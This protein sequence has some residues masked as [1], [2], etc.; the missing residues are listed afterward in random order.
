MRQRVPHRRIES[1][2]LW[3]A[4]ECHRNATEKVK[5]VGERALLIA[6][7]FCLRGNKLDELE[8]ETIQR[9]GLGSHVQV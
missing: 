6:R 5:E 7:T 3:Q 1:N 4:E 8:K 9:T 2:V